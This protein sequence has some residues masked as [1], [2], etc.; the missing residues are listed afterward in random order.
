MK[1][2]DLIGAVESVSGRNDI[3]RLASEYGLQHEGSPN[4][5]DQILGLYKGVVDG[6]AVIVRHWWYDRCKTY[7]VL[8]DG[9][10]V[11]LE[12]NGVKLAVGSFLADQ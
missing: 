12:V 1:V 4:K 7:Q 3:E 10:K 8:P 6:Q 2:S 5:I 9:N 11:E